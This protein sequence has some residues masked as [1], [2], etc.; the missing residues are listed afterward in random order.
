MKLFALAAAGLA[1]LAF[2]SVHA[3]TL[4]PSPITIDT[5]SSTDWKISN[6]VLTVDWLPNDGRIFSMH[7]SVFPDQEIIDQTNRSKAGPKGFY[8]DNA[9]LGSN[10]PSN[11]YYLDPR[12]RYID[13]WITEPASAT[14]AFTW[15]QHYLMFANDPGIHIYFTLDHGPGDIAG[16][17][18]QIQWVLRSD[19]SQFTN[20]YSVNSGLSNLGATTIPMPN[21]VLFGNSDPGRNVQDATEDLHGQTLPAG[22]RREFYTKYDYSSYEYLHRAEGVYGPNM[23]AWMVVQSRDTLTG[24]PT[25]QDLIFTGNLLIMEAYSNHLDNQMSFS[26]PANAVMHRLYGPFYLHFNAFNGPYQTPGSLY[27]EALTAAERVKREYAFDTQLLNSGYVPEWQ[28]GELDLKV[29]GTGQEQIGQTWAVL[30]DSATNMQYSHAGNEYWTAVGEDGRA[31][32]AGV[33]PGT[34][35]LTVYRLGGWGELRKDDVTV[36]ANRPT[37]MHVTFAPEDFGSH[38]PVWTIGTADRSAHEFLHG[39]IENPS[40]LDPNF[41]AWLGAADFPGFDAGGWDRV[42]D[43]QSIRTQ[44]D[45]EYWGNWNYW[46]DFAANQG[47]VVYYAT[48]IGSIPATN[49]LHQ[50]N[51]NQ[52]HVFNPGLFAGVYNP[53][54]DT[55][56]GY[57]YICP[58][59]V[60][61][62]ATTAV[63]DWQVHFATTDAQQAEGPYVTLSMGLAATESSLIVSLNGHPLVWPGYNHKNSDAA[64]RSGLSG[65]YQWAVLQW[66]S[67]VLNPPGQDNIL[68]FN[69]GRTQG[70]EYDALRMEISDRSADPAVTGW[71]D[72]DYVDANG[73]KA[74]NDAVGNQ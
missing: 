45:R 37:L 67:S 30:S 8:M 69:V 71:N 55:T 34:Y 65:T 4:G 36:P 52:W 48:P 47:A 28:R 72:Y 73:F 23:A 59:Y 68:T 2:P 64:V 56:D 61:N 41:P 14:N 13:W 16:S 51:Y 53:A 57:K 58:T 17:V 40:D 43:G 32:F 1:L 70:V 20:D 27:F 42:R 31:R 10:T 54:D 74:A 19:L 44:D 12:G 50:W 3:Q 6:G 22:F 46:A 15:S 9:G 7:W 25:K 63:P 21:D 24:G 39:Q 35:R 62:C 18:G 26:V 38:R 49:D 33:V 11:N 29:D 60:G 66:D 5:S